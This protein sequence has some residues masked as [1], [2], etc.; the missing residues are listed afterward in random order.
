MLENFFSFHVRYTLEDHAKDIEELFEYL[1]IRKFA[2][3]GTLMGSCY[4][5][6]M[7]SRN[8]DK[9]LAALVFNSM[10]MKLLQNSGSD[11]FQK[12]ALLHFKIMPTE[13][14]SKIIQRVYSRDIEET[15]KMVKK[16][17]NNE[18]DHKI[19]DDPTMKACNVSLS[20]SFISACSF[21]F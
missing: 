7:A 6:I 15:I 21:V 10:A 20:L 13:L 18:G 19:L 11:I 16:L 14:S 17:F 3:S 5:Y 1:G 4:V 12:L 2:V 9:V 8:P